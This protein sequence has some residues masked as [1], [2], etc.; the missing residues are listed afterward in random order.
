MPGP[1][2]PA[3]SRLHQFLPVDSQS[4]ESAVKNL[5]KLANVGCVV[6]YKWAT[7]FTMPIL[8]LVTAVFVKVLKV[9]QSQHRVVACPLIKRTFILFAIDGKGSSCN[10]T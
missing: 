5:C 8:V 2:H 10:K 9:G 6:E 3:F 7:N 4:G 1:L